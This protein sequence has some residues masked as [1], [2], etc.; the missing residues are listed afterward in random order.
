VPP[1]LA[2]SEIKPPG[3]A[4]PASDL[5]KARVW[6]RRLFEDPPSVHLAKPPPMTLT[7]R[8]DNEV[9]QFRTHARKFPV[10]NNSLLPLQ[11]SDLNQREY[12]EAVVEEC[13]R[14]HAVLRNSGF[15]APSE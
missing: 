11:K 15:V 9:R 13:V 14:H 12:C 5:D 4:I 1:A 2:S 7:R 8:R 3:D 6:L 10:E